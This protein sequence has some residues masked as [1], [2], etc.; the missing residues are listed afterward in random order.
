MATLE[1][2][3]L[4]H[5][6]V[7]G[8]ALAHL[9]RLA[10][11]WRLLAD[12]SF[13]DLLLLAPIAN[14][15]GHR[16]VVLAQVRPTTGQTLYV[17]DLV[18][19]VVDEVE[20]PLVTRAFRRAEETEGE[21]NVLGG[22]ERVRLQ[23]IPVRYRGRVIA[24][25]TREAPTTSGRRPGELERFYLEAFDRLA[26]MVTEGSFPFAREEIELEGAPRVG[27]GVILLDADA[28]IRYAS[29]NSVSSLH[30]MGIHAYTSGLQ[31][32]EIGFD[33][34]AVDTAVRARMPVIEEIERDD[35]SILVRVIPLLEDRKPAGA[36]ILL[37]DVTD[38]RRRDRMLMSKDAT[39]REIHHRVKN[40]LQ[41]IAALLRL[42]GRRLD[43]PEARQAIK[44]SERRIRSIAIVHETLS[45]EAREVVEFSDIVQPLLRVV[46]ETVSTGDD[47]GVRFSVE[48]D[49]GELPGEVATSLSVVLNELLQN[50]VDHAFPRGDG[51]NDTD[52]PV[53][54]SVTV[55]LSRSRED[56][57]VEVIDDGVGLP[58]DFSLDGTQ[59]LGLSIVQALVTGELGGTIQFHDEK[60]TRVEV[61]IPLAETA[62]T[63]VV[64]PPA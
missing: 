32:E 37:R 33:E 30:R 28:R 7:K 39:I 53:R 45:R 5:T 50:A 22:K 13:A 46:E 24:V 6:P 2:L 43:S 34:G 29:P 63:S 23:C 64:E 55:H 25:V 61:Q 31:L 51:D 8:D 14:E 19:H 49:A 41:T 48:G 10:L 56:L 54:G 16:F 12:L 15:D 9:Q 1:E 11:S 27:D 21:A 4:V 62:A 52:E 57:V 44:E 26:R 40:N 20:R 36:L 35:A 18:G 58:E 38:L 17:T 59:N 3:A 60:G 47:G 42:Q